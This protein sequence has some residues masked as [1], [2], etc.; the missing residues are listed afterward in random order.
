M[1]SSC[2]P[3]FISGLLVIYNITNS[4]EI[5]VLLYHFNNIKKEKKNV[6]IQYRCNPHKPNHIIGLWVLESL[7]MK[8]T[9]IHTPIHIHTCTYIHAYTHIHT[10]YM[11]AY[12]YFTWHKTGNTYISI[13]QIVLFLPQQKSPLPSNNIFPLLFILNSILFQENHTS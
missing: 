2:I 12:V 9:D 3:Q 1:E 4:L 6:C 8:H 11:Y 10:T 5:L 13:C 7:Y